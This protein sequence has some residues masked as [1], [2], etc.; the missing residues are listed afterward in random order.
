MVENEL[1]FLFVLKRTVSLNLDLLDLF[2]SL[3]YLTVRLIH[4]YYLFGAGSVF[5]FHEHLAL[6]CLTKHAEKVKFLFA[7][8]QVVGERI[9]GQLNHFDDGLL[10]LTS[11]ADQH[12]K[13]LS[14]FSPL[15]GVISCLNLYW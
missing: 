15:L 7:G 12:E 11:A 2:D 1:N 13:P 4:L 14:Q 6:G 9:E 3:F 10:G 5:T 8:R